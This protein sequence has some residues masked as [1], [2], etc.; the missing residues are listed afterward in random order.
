LRRAVADDLVAQDCNG[1]QLFK[2]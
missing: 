1:N 2:V